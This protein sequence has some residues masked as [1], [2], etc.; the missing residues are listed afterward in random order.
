MRK[1]STRKFDNNELIPKNAKRL[2]FDSLKQQIVHSINFYQELMCLVSTSYRLI[3]ST[4]YILKIK[5]LKDMIMTCRCVQ[6]P[7][8]LVLNT[9][10]SDLPHFFR[11]IQQ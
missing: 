1:L 2:H 10:T 9:D 8:L 3:S 5:D 11:F 6:C 4:F 7:T